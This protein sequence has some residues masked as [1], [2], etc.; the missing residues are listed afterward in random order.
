[1]SK[2]SDI[3]AGDI[4]YS[5]LEEWLIFVTGDMKLIWLSISTVRCEAVHLSSVLNDEKAKRE[6]THLGTSEFF[7]LGNIEELI[8]L[9]DK[10]I[11][12][13]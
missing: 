2:V 9:S 4:I 3:K 10:E 5:P 6:V 7:I 8:K 1:M 13:D 11:K 12:D